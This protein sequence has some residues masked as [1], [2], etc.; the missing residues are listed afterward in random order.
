MAPR[1]QR[2]RRRLAL[3]LLLGVLALAGT[4][5]AQP[6]APAPSPPTA[7]APPAADP[8]APAVPPS[9]G[10][11]LPAPPPGSVMRRPEHLSQRPSGFWTSNRPAQGGAY[12]Y[13][14]LA[15]GVLVLGLSAWLLARML[16]RVSRERAVAT[17]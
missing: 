8:Y 6:L 15:V 5:A 2:R 13:R 7:P 11:P 14:L 3:G 1:S 17:R 10:A 16:R 4:A 9:T 12:R